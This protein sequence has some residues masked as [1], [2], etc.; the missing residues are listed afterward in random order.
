MPIPSFRRAP[1][2]LLRTATAA[3]GLFLATLAASVG[4]QA[5]TYPQKAIE[6]IVPFSAGAASDL[7]TRVLA[8]ALEA[9]WGVPVR[10]VNKPGGNTVP[11]VNEV[12]NAKPDGY[13]LLADG[14][15][16]SSWLDTAVPDL[17]FKVTDRT[18]LGVVAFTPLLFIVPADSPYKTL[19]DAAA[20]LKAEPGAFT[21][22][23]LG[24]AGAHDILFRQFSRANGVDVARTRAIQ[25]KGGSEAVILVAG[26]HVKLGLA[27][28][29][30]AAAALKGGKVR[31]LAVAAPQRLPDLPDV[32]TAEELGFKDV[33]VYFWLGISGPPGLP[34]DVVSAWNKALAEVTAEPSFRK[35]LENVGLQPLHL[36]AKAAL[37][38]IARE[39]A[40]AQQLFAK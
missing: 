25:S 15:P 27:T 40:E 8:K 13:T 32:P 38:R 14:P 39:R 12:M 20:A 3:T 34:A 35:D 36:D 1:G 9:K 11:A 19:A 18:V 16:S 2:A 22:T 37:A 21:W 7:S 31:V 5:Q 4:A 24:G 23:S 6:L 30:G 26:N 28:P 29:G 10:A 17:P 33:E